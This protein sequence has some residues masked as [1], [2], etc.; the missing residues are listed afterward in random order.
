[1][2]KKRYILLFFVILFG[3]IFFVVF[4]APAYPTPLVPVQDTIDTSFAPEPVATKAQKDDLIVVDT[5]LPG[6]LVGEPITIT[7]RAR[8]NW[9]F[10]GSFPVVVTDWDGLI[11][12]EGYA[13]AKGEWMTTEY[14]PFSATVTYVLPSDTPYRR[15]TVI[16]QK[17]NASD[18][19]TLDNALE[20]PVNFK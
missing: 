3:S 19:R 16:L 2:I 10:E 12:G 5:P 8:G 17:N 14:V 11:I 1:M 20:I 13:T 15:G 7:G 9:F 6:A 18:D 4:N